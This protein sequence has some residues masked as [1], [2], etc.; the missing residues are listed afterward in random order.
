MIR[1]YSC[2]TGKIAERSTHEDVICEMNKSDALYWHK[3]NEMHE[4]SL[5]YIIVQDTYAHLSLGSGVRR[6]LRV[7]QK[8]TKH[9]S[10]PPTLDFYLYTHQEPILI[11]YSSVSR[12]TIFP[13][14]KYMFH[15]YP[16]DFLSYRNIPVTNFCR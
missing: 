13:V 4:L 9:Q 14:N 2:G 6:P 15:I 3:A 5:E 16:E 11:Y 8:Y 12:T 1:Y 7:V 10:A